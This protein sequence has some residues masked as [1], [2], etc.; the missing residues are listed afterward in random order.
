M[1]PPRTAAL[2][3]APTDIGAADRGAC[4]GPEAL[5][6]AGIEAALRGRDLEVHDLGNL[7]GRPIPGSRR[8]TATATCPRWCAG[9]S[10]CTRACTASCRL[11]RLPVLLG[12]DHRLAHRLDQRRGAPLPRAGQEAARAVAGCARRLQH[13]PAVP[14]RQ[15]PRHAGG[16]PVR[17]RPEG[18]DRH[19][20]AHAGDRAP[21]GC[22][23]SASA[24]ST[25][26]RSASCTSRGWTCS[27]CATSTRWACARR[28]SRPWLGW[29]ATRTCT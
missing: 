25:R 24:A 27:T 8:S 29:T 22:A 14:E 13:Q 16:L 18:A 20:R 4:M 12:G 3:G 9:T 15:H 26:A 17:L 7:N 21:R 11:G 1:R 10:W 23:R 28:S 19:R 5:R 2:I 6:V